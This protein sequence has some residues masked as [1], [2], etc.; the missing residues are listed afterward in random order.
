MA[1]KLTIRLDVNVEQAEYFQFAERVF[2]DEGEAQDVYNHAV[3]AAGGP[4][5]EVDYPVDGGAGSNSIKH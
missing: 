1:A 3:E 4:E 2:E 5:S